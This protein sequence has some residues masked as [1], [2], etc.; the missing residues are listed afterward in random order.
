MRGVKRASRVRRDV[1]HVDRPAAT[2]SV[3]TVIRAGLDDGIDFRCPETWLDAQI[4]KSGAG[5]LDRRYPVQF[6]KFGNQPFGQVARFHRS[7]FRQNHGGITGHVT[8]RDLAWKFEDDTATVEIG[9]KIALI[10]KR[11][12]NGL[13]FGLEE[14]ED[15]HVYLK[16]GPGSNRRSCSRMA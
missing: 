5:N 14:G 2:R 16:I 9:R 11:V 8:V 15:I 13:E 10:L 7:L 12:Q 4:Y 1:F 3:A 6:L